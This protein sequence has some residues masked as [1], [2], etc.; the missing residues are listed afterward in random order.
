[1]IDP[2]VSVCAGCC[3]DVGG[4]ALLAKVEDSAIET[5]VRVERVEC[6]DVCS[7]RP[8]LAVF[9]RRALAGANSE[10]WAFVR[11][12]ASGEF[13]GFGRYGLEPVDPVDVAEGDAA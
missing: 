11:D 2:V 3:L 8:A 4:D 12:V 10:V 6:L 9:E 1:M 13:E 7:D 5:G